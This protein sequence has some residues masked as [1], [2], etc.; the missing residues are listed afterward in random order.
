MNKRYILCWQCATLEEMH[1]D[2]EYYNGSSFHERT[3]AN[4]DE[5]LAVLRE[6]LITHQPVKLYARDKFIVESVAYPERGDIS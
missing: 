3:F 4:I 5:M 1:A 6:K 2:R